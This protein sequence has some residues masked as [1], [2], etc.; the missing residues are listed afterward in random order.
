MHFE[1]NKKANKAGFLEKVYLGRGRQC[2]RKKNYGKYGLPEVEKAVELFE[3][4]GIG[5]FY[6]QN[7]SNK[8]FRTTVTFTKMEGLKLRKPHR[9]N[10]IEI[11]VEPGHEKLATLTVSYRGYS[12]SYTESIKF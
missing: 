2:L 5:Y 1:K 9:G 11:S 3:D 4:E 6:L 8:K 7:R 10:I 12:L